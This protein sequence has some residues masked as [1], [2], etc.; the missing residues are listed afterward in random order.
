MKAQDLINA[1]VELVT[2]NG[3]PLNIF[4]DS[5]FKKLI[6]PI[7]R[8]INPPIAINE[9][10]IREAIIH[11]AIEI[12]NE[13]KEEIE[14]KLV[15]LKIDGATR[16]G[17]SFIGVNIQYILNRKII[18]RTLG[19]REMFE[20]STSE[21]LKN[22]ILNILR[23]YDI[24][25]H[26]IYTITTDDGS[27][28]L[29]LIQL[30]EDELSVSNSDIEEGEIDHTFLEKYNDDFFLEGERLFFPEENDSELLIGVRCVAHTLQLA[31]HD[32]L[33]IF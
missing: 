30:L 10:S 5:G 7:L 6:Q 22:L 12:R 27:N 31:V 23:E 18:I 3:R 4:T 19:L 11:K 21:N 17:R 9:N 8:T 2:K 14:N 13:I 33:Q 1:C 20:R 26:N 25:V 32:A 15:C 29:K 16:H 24:T 28:M